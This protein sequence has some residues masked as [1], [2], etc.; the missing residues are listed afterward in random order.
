MYS[1][2]EVIHTGLTYAVVYRFF[3]RLPWVTIIIWK[4]FGVD[5]VVVAITKDF[6]LFY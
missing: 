4:D 1:G 3:V 2:C 6:I 5:M